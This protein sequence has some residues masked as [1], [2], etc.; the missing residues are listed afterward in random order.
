MSEDQLNIIIRPYKAVQDEALIYS[1]WRNGMFYGNKINKKKKADQFFSEF[2]NKIKII[3]S[4]SDVRIAC[5]QDT[6]QVIV[7]YC[8]YTGD[9]LH[10][11]YV[12]PDPFRKKGIATLLVPK[13]IKTV[14]WELTK[15][16][17]EIARKKNLKKENP[18]WILPTP[19]Q[20]LPD[21]PA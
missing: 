3:L 18:S 13:H 1:T 10:W 11:V 9:H 19:P 21:W 20:T 15:I 6:P 7:G 4:N 16:G 2:T 17:E 8:V 12:K 14:P 5:M